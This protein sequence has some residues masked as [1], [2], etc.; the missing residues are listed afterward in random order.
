[1]TIHKAIMIGAGVVL[2]GSLTWAD[3]DRRQGEGKMILQAQLLRPA[4]LTALAGSLSPQSLAFW[5]AAGSDPLD[6]GS[7]E[8]R[9]EG[10]VEIRLREAAPSQSYSVLFCP[11]GAALPGCLP[12]GQTGAL[13]TDEKGNGRA[14]LDFPQPG[15]WAGVFLVRRAINGQALIE[16]VSGFRSRPAK[17]EEQTTELEI[18]GPIKSIDAANKSFRVGALPQDIFTDGATEFK[19][20]V[21]GFADL[22][23]DARVEVKARA[24]PQGRL[25]AVEVQG[26]GRGKG[27]DDD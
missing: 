20:S 12:A 2:A 16:Y 15:S 11:V 18:E 17:M 21:K 1:M 5:G 14:N 10:R 26:K 19:G 23:I 25:I 4:D 22:A 27:K 9:D 6:E 7:V 24:N 3:D 8:V 13:A